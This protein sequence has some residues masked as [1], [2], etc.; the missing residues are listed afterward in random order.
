MRWKNFFAATAALILLNASAAAQVVTVQGSGVSE[1]AAIKDAKRAA[2]EKII[3]TRITGDSLMVDSALVFDAVQSRSAGYVTSCEVI[4]KNS[5]GGLVEIT[6]RV[7]VFDEPGSALMKDIELVMTL[8]DPRLGVVVEHYGD[9]GGETFKKYTVQVEAAIREELIKRGFTHVVDARGEVDYVIVGRL[10]VGKAQEI[11]L[12]NWRNIGGNEF[13]LLDT[14]LSRSR[15]EMDCTIKKFDT[16][17]IIGEFHTNGDGTD[18][19]GGEVSGQAVRIM[20][21]DAARQVRGILSREASKVFSSVKIFVRT[22][23]GEKILALE[24]ILRQTQGVDNVYV[25]SFRGEQCVIDVGT[26]LT[27]QN[28][29]RALQ[30]A[31]GDSLGVQMTGFSSITLEI[32]LR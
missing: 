23:D 28:L 11:R 6:A 19:T 10:T 4:K 2:V 15:A 26:D 12:P 9:D 13:N 3:G 20:A 25:R 29:F 18:A 27:P 32:F 5:S 7:D 17:E 24:E 16:D 31:A 1:T 22:D 21:S 8:N 14:G 30:L